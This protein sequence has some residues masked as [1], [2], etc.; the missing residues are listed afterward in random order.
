MDTGLQPAQEVLHST[1]MDEVGV[2]A[3]NQRSMGDE[4]WAPNPYVLSADMFDCA[5]HYLSCDGISAAQ[6]DFI[7]LT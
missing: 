5:R 2:I 6:Q 4:F 3:I 7:S 1:Y